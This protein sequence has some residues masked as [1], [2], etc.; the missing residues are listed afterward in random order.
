MRPLPT[1]L[2]AAA[3]AV[4]VV[5]P[6]RA[7]PSA[8]TIA[9]VPF[10]K[11]EPRWCG[12]A[13]LESVLRYHGL[14]V[15]QREIADEIALPDGRVLNLDLKLYARRR[16][17]RAESARGS[18][19]RLRLWI[20]RDVPVICQVRV[21]APGARRNHFVVAYGYDER[22]SC[23]IA[24]TGERAAQEIPYLD[25]ARIWGDG[26]NWMLVIRPRPPRPSPAHEPAG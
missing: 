4:A 11:Q 22:R 16:G 18:C 8:H 13:A 24:H 1:A 3:I 14:Q 26:D 19:D 12:P 23:F 9:D 15:T 7:Q 17:L 25:F 20:A 10:V 5:L 21:G 6:V 2:A